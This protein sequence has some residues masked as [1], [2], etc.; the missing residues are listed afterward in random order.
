MNLRILGLLSFVLLSTVA[1]TS[2]SSTTDPQKTKPAQSAIGERP[3]ETFERI[4]ERIKQDYVEEVTD[5]KLLVGALNGML[6]A[7]DPHSAYL[8]P[9]VYEDLKAQTKGEFG[10]LGMEVTQENG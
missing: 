4:V 9:K 5:E 7:L 1:V 2:L 8:E 10:G 3:Y 6:S